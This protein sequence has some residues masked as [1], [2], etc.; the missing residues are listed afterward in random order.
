MRSL[1]LVLANSEATAPSYAAPKA[2]MGTRSLSAV[3]ATRG[4]SYLNASA[5]GRGW[6]AQIRLDCMNNAL[7]I[8]FLND[9]GCGRGLVY[10]DRRHG[11]LDLHFFR[12][13][14]YVD[15]LRTRDPS[16]KNDAG[17]SSC[18]TPWGPGNDQYLFLS[19]VDQCGRARMG[20]R[21]RVQ[22]L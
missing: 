4:S 15:G 5:S 11:L 3:I 17:S 14:T 8:R 19:S 10:G 20:T 7:I 18:V 16:E 22:V 1:Y 9:L 6:Q 13:I 2:D 21:A 12:P